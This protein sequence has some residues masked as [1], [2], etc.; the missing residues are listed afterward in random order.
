MSSTLSTFPVRLVNI[1]PTSDHDRP[2]LK[3]DQLEVVPELQTGNN[4][5]FE[6]TFALVR[7][8]LPFSWRFQ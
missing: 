2:V 6:Q 4:P 1:R 3:T 5:N 8:E 7:I